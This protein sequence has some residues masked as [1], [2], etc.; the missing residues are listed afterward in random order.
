MS[1]TKEFEERETE[2]AEASTF[3]AYHSRDVDQLLAHTRALEKML[4]KHE[5]SAYDDYHDCAMCPQCGEVEGK[6]YI[7]CELAKL[8]EG[9][10]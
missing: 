5:F 4:K 7:N 2:F 8:L 3:K 6:H 9:V 10:E 1:I